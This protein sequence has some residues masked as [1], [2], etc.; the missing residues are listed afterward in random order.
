MILTVTPHS[1]LDKVL[2]IDELMP[3]NVHRTEAIYTSVG[4]KGLDSS[5]TLS[6]LGVDTVGL[7]FV[8]GKTGQEL[9]QLV[10][11]FGIIPEPVWVDGETRI[12]HVISETKVG[13]HSHIISGKV[14][15]NQE[16]LDEFFRRLRSLAQDAS[17]VICAGSIP[18]V[19]S[20][21]IY[22]EI[23]EEVTQ[24]DVPVLIDSSRSPII[25]AI[26]A[27][28]AVIKMNWTE[29]EATFNIK[30]PTLDELNQKALQVYE[31]WE[32]KS[33][34]LTCSSQG[35]LAYSEEGSYHTVVPKL[36][37]VN[38]AGAGD[39]VSSALAW[40]FSEG[41]RWQ[42]ALRWAGAISAA[43]VLTKGTAE[44]RMEDVEDLLY[45]V[46]VNPI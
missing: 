33:L 11:N 41:D 29:F 14:L 35:I 16:Q 10:A 7:V 30:A 19:L 40:R 31:E 5:V 44:C 15:I 1:A 42:K 22:R 12:A 9:I 32:L 23:I 4:G 43:V 6:C 24:F 13:R 38:A 25:E 36:K 2:F 39:A 26:P 21:S 28:P 46:R 3:G 37:A 20:N 34:V 27:R 45:K 8:A 18:P 17:W